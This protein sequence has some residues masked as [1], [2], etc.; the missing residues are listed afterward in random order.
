MGHKIT[1]RREQSSGRHQQQQQGSKSAAGD[2]FHRAVAPSMSDTLWR[3][4]L[5]STPFKGSHASVLVLAQFFGLMP[6]NGILNRD[7]SQQEF[8]WMSLRTIYA[9]F[10]CGSLAVYAVLTL[11]YNFIKR[12]TIESFGKWLETVPVL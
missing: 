6:V 12:M 2:T 9:V 10:C 7:I 3:T 1:T 4:P 5:I 8:R 11:S